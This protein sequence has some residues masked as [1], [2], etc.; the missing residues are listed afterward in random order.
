MAHEVEEA[1]L[2][3]PDVEAVFSTIG[4]DVRAYAEGE[5][6]TGLHTASFQVRQGT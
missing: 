2:A 1:V 4:R 3:D 5:E 6:A